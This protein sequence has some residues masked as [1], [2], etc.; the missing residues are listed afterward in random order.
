[1]EKLKA[2]RIIKGSTDGT[3]QIG[4]IIWKSPNGD[5]N[6]VQGK[7]WIVPSEVD[8]RTLD[9]ECEEAEDYKVIRI[10]GSEICKPIER[11]FCRVLNW[12]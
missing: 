3:F 2:Y 12:E 10:G 4:E 5:I 9:F 7:G 1:M 11:W 6:S 8:S